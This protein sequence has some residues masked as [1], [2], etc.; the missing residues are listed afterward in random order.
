MM[1]D[2]LSLYF[3][4]KDFHDKDPIMSYEQQMRL[5]GSYRFSNVA[6]ETDEDFVAPNQNLA[7]YQAENS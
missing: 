4:N 3:Y 1:I 5:A 2:K 7:Y 6:G